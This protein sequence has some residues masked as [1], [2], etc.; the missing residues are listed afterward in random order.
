MTPWRIVCDVGGTNIRIARADDRRQITD[1]VVLPT[2][3]CTSMAT[4]LL[5]YANSFDRGDLLEGIAIAAAGPV[6]D[7]R[8][9]LTNHTLSIDAQI[10]SA[11]FGNRPVRLLNDLEAVAWSLPWLQPEQLTPVRSPD[12]PLGGPRLVVNVG[13]GFGGALLIATGEGWQSIAC[14]PGHMKLAR[15]FAATSGT[16]LGAGSVEETISG[17]GR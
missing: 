15:A 17:L 14:E 1:T 6:E 10:V 16:P 7:G 2:R 11:E 8:V 9:E 4:A 12:T 5:K 13:T 3:D